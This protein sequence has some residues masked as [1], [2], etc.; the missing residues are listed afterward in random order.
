M[1]LKKLLSQLKRA[2]RHDALTLRGE[3]IPADPG[4]YVW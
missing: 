4:L 2:Q 1:T 3:D